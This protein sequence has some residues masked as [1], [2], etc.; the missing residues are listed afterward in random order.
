MKVSILPRK[1]RAA[2]LTTRH[3]TH[4]TRRTRR[5]RQSYQ[6]QGKWTESFYP[7]KP[8]NRLYPPAGDA[9]QKREKS[10]HP[11]MT[12]VRNSQIDTTRHGSRCLGQIDPLAQ[13]AQPRHVS[14]FIYIYL[15]LFIYFTLYYIYIIFLYC[16]VQ[17]GG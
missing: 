7:I 10:R 1:L 13:Y 3:D 9:H 16:V 5:T 14:I 15:H 2:L 11:I 17:G 6:L 8:A 4:T 12:G